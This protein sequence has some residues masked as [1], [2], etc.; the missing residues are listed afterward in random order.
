MNFSEFQTRFD[1]FAGGLDLTA[2]P[3][4]ATNVVNNNLTN[5]LSNSP[6]HSIPPTNS[7]LM[8]GLLGSP[9]ITSPSKFDLF[10]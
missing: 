9:S 4:P 6:L 7:F 8:D 3:M 5:L 10:C 2:S 1:S